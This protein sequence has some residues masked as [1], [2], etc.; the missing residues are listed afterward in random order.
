MLSSNTWRKRVTI[1][2]AINVI[3]TTKLT[4]IVTTDNCDQEMAQA[5]LREIRADYPD[6]KK[7]VIFKDNAAYHHAKSV[8]KLAGE[9]NIEIEF[10]PAYSPNLNLIERIWKFMKSKF[11]N[12]YFETFEIFYD[13]VCKFFWEFEQ[14]KDETATILNYRFQI[15]KE[16]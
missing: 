14:Y 7:I 2:G 15:I 9:L 12:I 3:D 13:S 1:L 10:L 8:Q 16:A 4:S 5:L 11:K 6:G